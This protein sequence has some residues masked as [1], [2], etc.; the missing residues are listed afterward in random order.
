[1]LVEDESLSVLM[2]V[3]NLCLLL[4]CIKEY[5]SCIC[6]DVKLCHILG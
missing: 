5:E 3:D 4:N 6:A 1:M 2:L